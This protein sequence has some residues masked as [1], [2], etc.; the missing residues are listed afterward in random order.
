MGP[1]M[2][3]SQNG[4]VSRGL[5]PQIAT[6]GRYK[7][8]YRGPCRGGLCRDGPQSGPGDYEDRYEERVNPSRNA[9]RN[10]VRSRAVILALATLSR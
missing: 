4:S 8:S 7:K 5:R 9:S 6:Q 10:C 1:V 3:R 2:P